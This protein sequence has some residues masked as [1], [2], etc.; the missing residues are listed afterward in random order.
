MTQWMRVVIRCVAGAAIGVLL[1]LLFLG[2]SFP[3]LAD[4]VAVA[5]AVELELAVH[6]FVYASDQS[7]PRNRLVPSP[8]YQ[9]AMQR[10]GS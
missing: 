6:L 7:E 3:A 5:P 2:K 1:A 9:R 10:A 4:P 8:Y